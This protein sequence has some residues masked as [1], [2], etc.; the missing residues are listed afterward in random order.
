MLEHSLCSARCMSSTPLLPSHR[1]SAGIVTR[2]FVAVA[3]PPSP[4]LSSLAWLSFSTSL[5]P[6]FCPLSTEFCSVN[7][8]A[9]LVGIAAAGAGFASLILQLGESAAQL[10]KLGDDYKGAPDTLRN[11]AFMVETMQ[12]LLQLIKDDQEEQDGTRGSDLLDRCI[13]MCRQSLRH[14]SRVMTKLE[15]T[16]QR[17]TWR[18]K[19]RTAFDD[20]QLEQLCTE[21][22]R[23]TNVLVFG[24]QYFV[25]EQQRRER[26]RDREIVLQQI[27]LLPGLILP[28]Q[29]RDLCRTTTE[30]FAST[31]DVKTASTTSRILSTNTDDHRWRGARQC[32]RRKA[33]Y[34]TR[35]TVHVRPWLVA[36]SWN[37]SMRY[38]QVGWNLH[39]RTDHLVAD[40]S[41]VFYFAERGDLAAV[42]KLFNGGMARPNTYRNRY[43]YG[44]SLLEV[45]I[46]SESVDLCRYIWGRLE[47]D[48]HAW[49]LLSWKAG[50]PPRYTDLCRLLFD[51]ADLE[52]DLRDGEYWRALMHLIAV[53]P[54]TCQQF[55]Q[56]QLRHICI[57]FGFDWTCVHL[58][59]PRQT[60][61]KDFMRSFGWDELDDDFT[62]YRTASGGTWLH[63]LFDKSFINHEW[64]WAQIQGFVRALIQAGIDVNVQDDD[65]NT[66]LRIMLCNAPGLSPDS[67]RLI[68]VQGALTWWVDALRDTGFLLEAYGK[69]EASLEGSI[70]DPTSRK[71][72][73]FED[74]NLLYRNTGVRA[75]CPSRWLDYLSL[76]SCSIADLLATKFRGC[77][78]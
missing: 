8:M 54:H 72:F 47:N 60:S 59:T 4:S 50:V 69:I 42:Q 70:H 10:K 76:R 62:S 51:G 48:E 44:E 30:C 13:D 19:L 5:S 36:W 7:T 58:W 64:K 37:I 65:G 16:M 20:K 9:E 55:T 43:G 25:Q 28:Q 27:A 26:E 73:S 31:S 38:S 41:P 3:M 77:I 29:H 12:Q 35:W 61:F 57:K 67:R 2:H 22:N 75:L 52:V 49:K 14:M 6:F 56:E 71:C 24:Y 15:E 68:L 34:R 39:Y 32:S 53:E 33:P 40:D 45:A 74:R 46:Q 63:E 18:G 66:C 17:S 23:A 78:E 1:L 11:T 21:L